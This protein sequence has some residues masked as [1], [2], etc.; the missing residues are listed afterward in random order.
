MDPR[1]MAVVFTA[2][3]RRQNRGAVNPRGASRASRACAICSLHLTRFVQILLDRKDHMSMA[4]GLEVDV[5]LLPA[6]RSDVDNV[7]RRD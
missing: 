2:D 7:R 3:R 1:A 5:L 4:T 6:L